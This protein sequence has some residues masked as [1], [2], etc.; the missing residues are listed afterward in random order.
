MERVVERDGCRV[1]VAIVTTKNFL[2][3]IMIRKMINETRWNFDVTKCLTISLSFAMCYESIW[4][5]LVE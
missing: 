3:C 4:P 5:H 1:G 2:K